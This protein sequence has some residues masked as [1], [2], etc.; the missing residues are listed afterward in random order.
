MWKLSLDP[1]QKTLISQLQASDLW[2]TCARTARR[3]LVAAIALGAIV[4]VTDSSFAQSRPPQSVSASA[5]AT[6]TAAL[7]S[8]DAVQGA[9]T[10]QTASLTCTAEPGG[11]RQCPADTSAGVALMKSTG[12]SACLLGKTWGYDS[13]GVWVA[14]GCGGEFTLGQGAAGAS[15]SAA[16]PEYVPVETWGEFDPGS[17]FLL[18][19]S[20]AGELSI[21]GYALTRYVNQTPGEQTFIDHLGNERTVDGRN[22]IWPH[23]VMIFLKGWVGNPRLIYAV[24]FW[25]VLDTNQN[26]IFGNI[27][28]QFSRK[29]SVY[30]GLNGHPGTRSLQGSH[31]FWLGQDRVM[32]DEFFRPFFG[33]GVWAQGEA[34][35][36]LWYNV[37]LSNTNSILGVTSSELDRNIF[38][39]RVDVV[40]AHDQGIRPQGRLRRLGNAPEGGDAVRLLHDAEPGAA[41]HQRFRR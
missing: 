13:A 14:D 9:G 39:R 28:Y 25:T 6:P 38:H 5:A 16:P 22:D 15:A 24:T 34:V 41:L 31:P 18:G 10:T 17:G 1:T 36:G 2:S 33:S 20:S 7:P 35:P 30:A 8:S 37:M 27:G 23:R 21:S 29:F 3:H 26:A 32:A 40:D 11:R 4:L 19:R 12:P